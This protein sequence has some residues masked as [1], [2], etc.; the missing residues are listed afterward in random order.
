MGE[1][2]AVPAGDTVVIDRLADSA[3]ASHSH[4]IEEVTR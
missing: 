2:E 4:T 1:T 3:H